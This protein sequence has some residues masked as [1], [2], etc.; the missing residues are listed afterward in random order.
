VK[1]KKIACP[2]YVKDTRAIKTSGVRDKFIVNYIPIRSR[3]CATK[4]APL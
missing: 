3:S 1:L 2:R 4:R